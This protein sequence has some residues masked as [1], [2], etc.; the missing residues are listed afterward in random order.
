MRIVQGTE[1]EKDEQVVAALGV[2]DGVHTG[3][4]A[5][6]KE[7]LQS[8][9][10][11]GTPVCV[12]TFHP[13]P[14]NLLMK[15]RSPVSLLTPRDEKRELLSDLGLDL[16]WEMPFTRQ[17]AQ[18]PPL[19]FV[20]KY[21][22]EALRVSHVVCGF[23]FTFGDR[24][25]GTPADL[26]NWGNEYGFKVS[27]IPP[28]LSGGEVVSST[29]IRAYLESGR[30][31][32]AWECLGRPYCVY[33][34]VEHG[35]GRGRGIG[36]PTSNILVPEDKMIPGNGVYAA[37]VR[38]GGTGVFWRVKRCKHRYQADLWR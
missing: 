21:L 37:L 25:R 7:A 14:K 5:L 34:T 32:Q 12:V 1:A 30:V 29:R 18:T 3:H 17:L 31:E 8:G 4:Q 22:L 10:S 2:F 33:G 11:L 20:R 6:L 16:Y 15:A 26:V 19:D 38:A 13:H 27:V 9:K 24:G 23:N 36:I 35:D 28:H